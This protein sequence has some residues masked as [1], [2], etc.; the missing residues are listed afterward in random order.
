M[1]PRETPS[2]FFPFVPKVKLAAL[3]K[4]AG[5]EPNA[6]SRNEGIIDTFDSHYRQKENIHHGRFSSA[7]CTDR[8]IR[9]D[10]ILPIFET[11]K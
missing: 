4:L 6:L 1:A 11:W 3:Q 9:I 5:W 8:S 10:N 7:I 2:V